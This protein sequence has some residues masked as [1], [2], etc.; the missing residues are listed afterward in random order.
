MIEPFEP[1]SSEGTV[2][3]L[4]DPATAALLFFFST[5]FF[6]KKMPE[7]ET[8]LD[9][10]ITQSKCGEIGLFQLLRELVYHLMIGATTALEMQ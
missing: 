1:G 9:D 8:E 5:F 2:T 6:K 3:F 10:P 7:H 4:F